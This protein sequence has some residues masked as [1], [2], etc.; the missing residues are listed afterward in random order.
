MFGNSIADS[1]HVVFRTRSHTDTDGPFAIHTHQVGR[2]VH[3]ATFD[4][5]DITQAHFA[6]SLCHDQ[7]V[8][9]ILYAFISTF[10][11]YTK[12]VS[13]GHDLACIDQQVLGLQDLLDRVRVDPQVCQLGNG[14]THIHDLRLFRKQIDLLH[15]LDRSQ[16]GLDLLRPIAHIVI[17]KA[18]VGSQGIIDTE[19]VPEIIAHVNGGSTARKAGLYVS[20][21][22]AQF[23]PLDRHIIRSQ[24][25][26][27]FDRDLRHA[28]IRFRLDLKNIRHGLNFPFDRFRYQFF[29]LL[30][31]STRILRNQNS[32]FD[33]ERRVL[34]FRQFKERIYTPDQHHCQKEI[35]NLL[36]L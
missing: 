27:Q 19:H 9:Y 7:L 14:D 22:T 1:H 23:I 36:I 24:S 6:S 11:T 17:S 4:D 2:W 25:R 20:H 12:L 16:L 26:L 21:L 30:R 8:A 34:L 18:F 28:E 13:P 29:Y 31:S 32:L 15:T 10:G 3:I 33:Y 35:Y 5:S